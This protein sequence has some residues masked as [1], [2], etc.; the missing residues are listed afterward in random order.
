MLATG[1]ADGHATYELRSVDGGVLVQNVDTVSE[2]PATFT[3]PTDR[4]PT[5]DEM[6]EL[7]SPGASARA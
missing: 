3:Y 5:D 6:A 7:S 4:K 1:G 2:D